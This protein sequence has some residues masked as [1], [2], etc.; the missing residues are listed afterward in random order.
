MTSPSSGPRGPGCSGWWSPVAAAP[1]GW[2]TGCIERSCAPGW[3]RVAAARLAR[4]HA[5]RLEAHGLRRAD[6][7]YRV[8]LL[9][10]DADGQAP[11]EVLDAAVE[12]A[13]AGRDLD[14]IERLTRAGLV[15]SGSPTAARLLAEVLYERG[16]FDEADRVLADALAALG[17]A[18]RR[19]RRRSG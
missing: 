5:E 7:H 18:D 15:A 13:R 12:L 3:A 19:P 16:R 14:S 17:D 9:R 8:A 11:P 4:R 10:L 1:S 6:D 2:R